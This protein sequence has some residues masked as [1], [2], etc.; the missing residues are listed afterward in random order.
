[1]ALIP[2]PDLLIL[3]EPTTGLDVTV[4]A[5]ILDLLQ[6]LVHESGLTA[7]VISHD[8][9]VIAAICD[10]VAVMFAGTIVE[11]G[12]ARQVLEEPAHP[13]TVELA[14]AAHSIGPGSERSMAD[15]L[16]TSRS[17]SGCP[18]RQ[19]CPRREAICEIEPALILVDEQH[20]ARCHF[21]ARILAETRTAAE[22]QPA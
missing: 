7:L 8:L 13:Y 1:M 2:S 5:E 3:D 12:A 14:R 11:H 4:Q 9:A 15:L 21:A 10:E 19:R 22:W 16:T 18:F 6:G 20:Q 17:E